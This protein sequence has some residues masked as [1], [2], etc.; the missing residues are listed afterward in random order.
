[1]K[2]Y[3]ILT[4]LTFFLISNFV[5]G[6]VINPPDNNLF[7][8]RTVHRIDV[9][10]PADTMA[11]LLEPQNLYKDEYKRANFTFTDGNSGAKTMINDVG[12]RLRGNTSRQADKKSFKIQFDEYVAGQEL[13][14]ADEINLK[15][16]HNDPTLL[17]E[18]L[19]YHLM[20]K[21]Q[22]PAAR[23]AHVELY[24]NGDYRGLYVNVEHYDKRFLESRF[25]NKDGNLYKCYYGADL[26]SGNNAYDDG[27]FELK[28]NKTENIRTKL[29]DLI[30]VL[31]FSPLGTFREDIMA[32]L[33]VDGLMR[34]LAVEAIVGHWDGYSYNKNNYYL[35]FNSA[36]QKFEFIPYD[37]DNTFGI[38]W[39]GRDWANRN[40][41]SFFR[42]GEDRPLVT[43]LLNIREF[44]IMYTEYV[45]QL[46]T[47]YFN[48][49]YLFPK[50]DSLKTLIRPYVVSDTYYSLDYGFSMSDFDNSFTQALGGH[51]DY[52]LKPYI[53][54]RNSSASNQIDQV[55]L[56]SEVYSQPD[57]LKI[58]NDGNEVFVFG[59]QKIANKEFMVFNTAGQLVYEGY[60]KTYPQ[61]I[62]LKSGIYLISIPE[63]QVSNKLIMP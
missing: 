25:G 56:F 13:D 2:K 12:F 18:A 51:V 16:S 38:D 35:Y 43:R 3:Q 26:E 6:Q 41:Y 55:A 47:T 60:L 28:T 59:H 20:D 58:I 53:S 11:W 4:A 24:I 29:E 50:I 9:T 42:T 44:H 54:T 57:Y 10:I 27:L 48:D 7:D 46:V 15:G 23:T 45:N 5:F 63:I 14:G 49:A 17:R 8:S 52:G 61:R 36:T 40:I 39:V 62:N 34:Y 21:M 22:I 30:D 31:N 33:N 37:P 19:S 1:M 32:I